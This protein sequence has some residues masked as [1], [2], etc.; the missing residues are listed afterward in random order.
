MACRLYLSGHKTK[1]EKSGGVILPLGAA[2]DTPEATDLVDSEGDGQPSE[3]SVSFTCGPLKAGSVW[4]EEADDRS[5]RRLLVLA[6]EAT[7][8]S[9]LAE[10]P[11]SGDGTGDC[12]SSACNLG[13]G[14]A[15]AWETPVAEEDFVSFAII[16]C[17]AISEGPGDI[18][19]IGMAPPPGVGGGSGGRSCFE[20]SAVLIWK[21]NVAPFPGTPVAAISP[22]CS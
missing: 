4:K 13:D 8:G 2:T 11:A 16:G 17:W 1:I 7:E 12:V 22:P 3:G 10:D 18:G 20:G 21:V 5:E 14:F 15:P 6:A 9:E 19:K